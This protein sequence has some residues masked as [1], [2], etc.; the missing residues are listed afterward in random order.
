MTDD[1]RPDVVRRIEELRQII[2]RH[3]Y[4]Y[5]VLDAS[6]ISDQE[7]DRLLRE[8][9]QLEAYFPDLITPD[10]PTQRVGAP[11]SEAF[12]TVV[13]RQP[14]LSL[15]NAFSEDELRAW[16]R[17]I[18][19]VLGDQP[20]EYV[21]ELKIDG[22]AVS[23]T[24]EHG[25]F[26]RGATRGDGTHG[27]D[28]TPNLKTI[29]SLPLRLRLEHLPA[30]A[31]VRGEAF[32]PLEAFAALNR[33]RVAAGEPE[34]ANPRNA[35]AGSLRQ[36]D[37]QV[38]ASR[39]LDIFIYG[40]GA[41]DGVGF[42]THHQTLTWLKSA[43]FKSNPHTT[44]CPSL[45]QVINYVTHWTA[46]RTKLAYAADGVV[47]KVN[48]LRQQAELGAT[49][50]A[51]R[52]AIAFKFPAE[53]AVTRVRAIHVYVGR[54]G[55]L[56]PVAELE[57]VR[58]SG[59][60]VASATLHN[61][62][63][64]RRKDVRIGDWVIVQRAGEVIP[65]VVQVLVNRRTGDE[66]EFVMPSICPACGAAVHRE[67]GE[68]VARCTNAACPSQVLG[69]LIHFCSRDAMHIEG[70]GPRLLMQMLRQSLIRDAADLYRLQQDQLMTLERMGETSAQNVLDAIAGSKRTTLARL[71]YAL[72]IRH[73]GAHVAE[74]LAM[75]CG[76]LDRLVGASVEEVRDVAGVG[77]AIAQ[78]VVAFFQQEENRALVMRLLEAGVLPA[79]MQRP[80]SAGPL[81]GK[82]VVFTGTLARVSRNRA[83]EIVK[84]L[85]GVVSTTVSKKTDFVVV[86]AEPGLKLE[87]ARKLGIRA[88]T[89]EEFFDL[90]GSSDTGRGVQIRGD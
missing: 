37:P 41:V 32:L 84:E 10:S 18:L 78:S 89:E 12:A 73:V 22:A 50:Q 76:D 47:V 82:Q 25:R 13:H 56:T 75:H 79:A 8:L 66:A 88:L 81:A 77:P 85:G 38:T 86:G 20:L 29:R 46:R 1:R 15:A 33:D 80:A 31:E 57:P 67:E 26:V 35:A 70:V 3:H 2:D 74:A 21:C 64:V 42:T 36:L 27:E 52:W 60:T 11:P 48:D 68:A 58:V 53:Q 44:R 6:E 65:E 28:V 62:D 23:L 40:V 72:G 87:K 16:V 51:P 83:E 19:G 17:R 49:S 14:M 54:T 45:D 9:Q 61:E 71:L 43:G 55:A 59:V 24:Y 5:Y 7:Y 63:E 30:V 4:L 69:S 39:P 90:I 34:F